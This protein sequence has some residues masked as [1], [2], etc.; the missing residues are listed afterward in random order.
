MVNRRVYVDP[1]RVE[2]LDHGW[3]HVVLERLSG[4]VHEIRHGGHSCCPGAIEGCLVPVES[5]DGYAAPIDL[6]VNR[7][8]GARVAMA[9]IAERL[10]A[11]RAAV[12]MIRFP[13]SSESSPPLGDDPGPIVVDET[14]P[15]ETTEAHVPVTTEFGPRHP[16]PVRLRP[17][18]ATGDGR[19]TASTRTSPR[20]TRLGLGWRRGGV[21]GRNARTSDVSA[22]LSGR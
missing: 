16:G 8:H 20:H 5:R 6:F 21:G 17:N 14:R 18:P 13:A 2:D 12:A 4:V 9:S 15:E 3:F 10:P 19:T 7:L 11:L 1:D 22:T